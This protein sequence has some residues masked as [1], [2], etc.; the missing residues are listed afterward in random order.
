MNT[1]QFT[2]VKCLCALLLMLC[3]GNLFA[4]KNDTIYLTNGDRITGEIKR[5]EHGILVLSTNGMGNLNIEFDD[6]QTF[7]SNK[8]F[9]IMSSTGR[10]YFGSFGKSAEPNSVVVNLLND[11]VQVAI[12]DIVEFYPIKESFFK[13]LDGNIDVGYRYAKATT[14]TQ[15][16]AGLLV[17]HRNE[18]SFTQ[19]RDDVI[20]TDQENQDVIRNQ[21]HSLTFNRK[22]KGKW[23]AG[24][25]IGAQQNT[26]LGT[27]LRLFLGL[28]I[29]NDLVFT[30]SNHLAVTVGALF[31]NETS[32]SDTTVQ[33][34]EGL[35]QMNYRLFRFS[36][37][38][39]DVTS[40]FNV[41]PSFTTKNRVRLEFEL[42][43]KV[44]IFHDFFFSITLY[45]SYDN[46]PFDEEAN[47]NDWGITT[48]VGYSF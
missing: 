39:I 41:Y 43:G 17:S 24:S 11:S 31:V 4:Q 18:K 5:F 22:F 26:E 8:H 29:G 9:K 38:E 15:F 33:S 14:L 47:T 7:F 25:N 3:A 42:K 35:F 6:L 2:I 46:K 28:G 30:N 32:V 1:L 10:K 20:F 40:Y 16:N 19:L 44:E 48:S 13:R 27:D 34:V 36:K 21:D 37:P 45:D 12:K 23:Y